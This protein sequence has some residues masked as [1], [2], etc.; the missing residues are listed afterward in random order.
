MTA[1]IDPAQTIPSSLIPSPLILSPPSAHGP[2]AAPSPNAGPRRG[3]GAAGPDMAVIH[4]TGMDSAAAALARL[5]DPAAAV[6]AHY[7]IDAA[8]A[9]FQLVDEGDRAWHAG[10]SFWAGE[11]D[12]NSRS[13]GIELAHGGDPAAPY[14]PAQMAALIALI[15]GAAR[16]WPIPPER[17]L[18]HSDVA[19]GRKADPGPNF[20]WP[21]LAAAGLAAAPPAGFEAL[22]VPDPAT[23][24]FQA[25]HRFGYGAW[26]A[27]AVLAA[28]RHR[29]H[30]WL[31]NPA[32]RGSKPS[33]AEAQLMVSLT[34]CG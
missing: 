4:H 1:A 27:A 21:A 22:A 31:P 3:A 30:R 7:L 20:D 19:P 6:S 12:V 13:I 32:P 9:V 5:R 28:F 8:G 29:F 18:G 23:A 10:V 34:N 26:P 14:P 24:F 17:V 25:A 11:R 15:R 16:R 33:L 2:H